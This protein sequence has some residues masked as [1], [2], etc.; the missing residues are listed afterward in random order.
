MSSKIVRGY[1][2]LKN[3]P[4]NMHT[5]RVNMQRLEDES[6]TLS[7]SLAS[8]TSEI[9]SAL[10]DMAIDVDVVRQRQADNMSAFT[11]LTR[12][13]QFIKK[14]T[15]Q[16]GTSQ[17]SELQADNHALDG[18]YVAFEN[19]FRGSENEIYE[20]LKESYKSLLTKTLPKDLRDLPI[21]DIGC[22]RGEMLRLIKELGLKGIGIDLNGSMVDKCKQ[23]GYE[24]EQLDALQFLKSRPTS[25]LAAVGGIHIVEHIPFEQ[26]FQLFQECYRVVAPGGFVFFETPN[27]ENIVV[28]SLT[29]W[30]DSSHLKPVPP[31][32]LAFV[33]K[34]VGFTKTNIM[35]MHPAKELSPEADAV[36]QEIAA[37]VFG[38]RD[39]TAI[40]IKARN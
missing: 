33:L 24:A 21:I 25:S 16:K 15:A 17:A 30:Y 36:V 22:G 2:F 38:P 32:A 8:K 9:D 6:Q 39:Y 28:G 14:N 26:L 27:P 3:L 23:D 18:Y 5:L 40:G 13:P 37:K 19:K 12:A 11:E 31:E 10:R 1:R 34:Y 20:R 35:R 4:A 7:T 29:F